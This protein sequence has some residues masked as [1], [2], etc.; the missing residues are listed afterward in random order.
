M[1]ITRDVIRDLIPPYLAGEASADTRALV[2]QFLASDPEFARTVAREPAR[3]AAA[4]IPH[5]LTK[6]IEM[7]TIEE[8]KRTVK[9]QS[10][11]MACAM[12]F[13]AIPFAFGKIDDR[14]VRWLWIDAPLGAV[15]SAVIGLAF[16]AV[17][18]GMRRALRVRGL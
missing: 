7:R 2:E 1:N 5:T 13:S 6:E 18:L 9:L 17:Y 3:F 8:T 15:I 12:M 10:V 14:G 16:W 4:P 11:V